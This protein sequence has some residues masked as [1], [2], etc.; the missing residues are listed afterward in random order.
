MA[1]IKLLMFSDLFLDQNVWNSFVNFFV[2]DISDI[3]ELYV[4]SFTFL[5]YSHSF[6]FI[7]IAFPNL[8]QSNYVGDGVYFPL[9]SA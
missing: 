9:M 6:I 8:Y 1:E 5:S 4:E 3:T 7:R 2:G